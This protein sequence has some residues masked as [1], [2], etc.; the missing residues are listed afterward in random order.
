M[1]F[2]ARPPLGESSSAQQGAPYTFGWTGYGVDTPADE[3]GPFLP[4]TLFP[5]GMRQRTT[6]ILHGFPR[7]TKKPR[8]PSGFKDGVSAL[9]VTDLIGLKRHNAAWYAIVFGPMAQPG[10]SKC[11]EIFPQEQ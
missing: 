1:A 11:L 3:A 8:A 4:A 7:Q 10:S 9:R 5:G 6:Q 2:L